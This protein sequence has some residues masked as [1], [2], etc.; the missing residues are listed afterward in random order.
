MENKKEAVKRLRAM[1]LNLDSAGIY[2]SLKRIKA[3]LRTPVG[4]TY[5]EAG[6]VLRKLRSQFKSIRGG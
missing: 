4:L 6:A 5:E 2:P 1:A 3:V